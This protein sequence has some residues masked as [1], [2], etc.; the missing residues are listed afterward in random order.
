MLEAALS[1]GKLAANCLIFDFWIPFHVGSGSKTSSA[2]LPF[3]FHNTVSGSGLVTLSEKF[4]MS[5]IYHCLAGQGEHGPWGHQADRLW[6]P[7]VQPQGNSK[8]TS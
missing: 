2:K 3:K 4:A 8:N 6:A 1:P 7:A 5:Y